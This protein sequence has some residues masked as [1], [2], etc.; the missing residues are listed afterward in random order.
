MLKITMC[1]YVSVCMPMGACMHE[2]GCAC[3][4]AY[5]LVCAGGRK[6]VV[7]GGTH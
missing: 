5:A 6:E 7:R 1:A 4:R 3:V 2:F